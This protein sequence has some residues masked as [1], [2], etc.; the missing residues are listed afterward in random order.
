MS[1]CASSGRAKGRALAASASVAVPPDV[2]ARV[3]LSLQ[4]V[5]VAC[6][7]SPAAREEPAV[8]A[9]CALLLF[10]CVVAASR[11]PAGCVT[12][13]A[14]P[15]CDAALRSTLACRCVAASG[16]K[17]AARLGSP[18]PAPDASAAGISPA[19]PASARGTLRA[20]G[21]HS[22]VGGR[23]AQR[24]GVVAHAGFDFKQSVQDG[25]LTWDSGGGVW[26]PTAGGASG[27][28][29]SDGASGGGGARGGGGGSGGGGSSREGDEARSYAWAW[30]AALFIL[31]AKSLV[32]WCCEDP[33]AAATNIDLGFLTAMSLLALASLQATPLGAL[34]MPLVQL[35]LAHIVLEM[36]FYGFLLNRID[37]SAQYKMAPEM[38]LHHAAVALGGAHILAVAARL[39]GAAAFVWVG[40]QLIVTEVTTCLPVAF[41]QAVKNKRLRGPRSAVLGLLFPSAFV[42]RV[43][44]SS[45]VVW[46][47]G[48]VVAAVGGPAAV[49]LWWVSGAA[50]TVI[51]GLNTFWTWKI[52]SGGI[53]AVAK[54]RGGKDT[55]GERRKRGPDQLLHDAAQSPAYMEIIQT[56]KRVPR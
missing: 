42:L 56:K 55:G 54:R 25:T 40:T 43:F 7:P 49:P 20:P 53:K 26:S 24:G 51:L 44:W 28:D 1:V 34:R 6:S 52:V 16:D 38:W 39:P 8:A 22:S 21:S 37:P 10:L 18:R 9:R 41:H 23:S 36:L 32:C 11:Q 46:N 27:G 13:P 35:T 47:Y 45:R 4:A 50:S 5:C 29:S 33:K 14:M 3:W 2:A 30:A 48:A 17:L 19:G 31:V 15:P 12:V